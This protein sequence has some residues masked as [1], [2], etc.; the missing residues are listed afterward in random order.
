MKVPPKKKP[1]AQCYIVLTLTAQQ[2]SVISIMYIFAA[3][4][5]KLSLFALFL[6]IFA[7]SRRCRLMV[8]AGVVFTV[9]SYV[10]L[11]AA[12]TACS[13]PGPDDGNWND[14]VFFAKVGRR[15]PTPSVA[16][17]VVGIVSDFYVIAI[18]LTVV[19]RL[20]LSFAKRLGLS[21]LFATGLLYVQPPRIAP[22]PETP[23]DH[24]M[25]LT[26]PPFLPGPAHSPLLVWFLAS[27]ITEPPRV[28]HP[29][30]SGY[31]WSRTA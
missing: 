20:N 28:A 3:A 7:P 5:T 18:P 19:S 6:R 11:L 27:L 15:T 23:A 8:W 16:L 2:T 30:P 22:P 13:V 31:R 9:V 17:A 4:L 10:A 26:I 24:G 14:P 12:W 29:I 1:S 21:A 25:S